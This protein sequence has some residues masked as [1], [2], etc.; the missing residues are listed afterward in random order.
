MTARFAAEERLVVR[1]VVDIAIADR[2]AIGLEERRDELVSSSTRR[3]R[4]RADCAIGAI[5]FGAIVSRSR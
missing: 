2:V 1:I 5:G 4:N 3:R